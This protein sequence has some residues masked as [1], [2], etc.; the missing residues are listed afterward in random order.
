M[1][2]SGT[3]SDEARD[4]IWWLVII[5]WPILAVIFLGG[6]AGVHYFRQW[7]E[8]HSDADTEGD[9]E[10]QDLGKLVHIVGKE[11]RQVVIRTRSRSKIGIPQDET[12]TRTSR[13][14]SLSTIDEDSQESAIG[15]NT[16]PT[17]GCLDETRSE[18]EESDWAVEA[19]IADVLNV[20][21]R[22]K[23][24]QRPY[25]DG[26]L[27]TGAGDG[28]TLQQ[29][30]VS[31]P[32]R[33]S[34]ATGEGTS[35][36]SSPAFLLDST[37]E[38]QFGEGSLQEGRLSSLHQSIEPYEE[39]STDPESYTDGIVEGESG[40]TKFAPKSFASS[41]LLRPETTGEATSTHSSS[42]PELDKTLE[43]QLDGDSPLEAFLS[44]SYQPLG[45]NDEGSNEQ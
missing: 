44:L 37:V 14:P 25:T 42:S 27:E 19:I 4:V 24:R 39:D 38:A 2:K 1:G 9:I 6:P 34:G 8:R 20:P 40:K 35:I 28:E 30:I 45:P 18:E 11:K 41:P 5:T 10:L 26:I 12:E 22:S 29:A 7:S 43:A 36:L 13:R 33:G 21:K 31:S 15:S 23:R 32:F 3:V 17:K 16:R